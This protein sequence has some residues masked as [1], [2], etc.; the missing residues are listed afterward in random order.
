MCYFSNKFFKYFKPLHK[1]DALQT[2]ERRKFEITDRQTLFVFV[3]LVL[4]YGL[5]GSRSFFLEV[6][7]FIF[8]DL[9]E[10]YVADQFCVYVRVIEWMFYGQ[11]FIAL[12]LNL[13]LGTSKVIGKI[14][15]WS[16]LTH[17]MLEKPR[18]LVLR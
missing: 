5:F 17:C 15:R 10:K 18:N 7:N 8:F 9:L 3:W 14:L 13:V 16:L 6:E 12:V 2:D 11:I 1:L 4:I